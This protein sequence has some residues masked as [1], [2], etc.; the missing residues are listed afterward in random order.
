MVSASPRRQDDLGVDCGTVPLRL[1]DVGLVGREDDV[2]KLMSLVTAR[3]G[4]LGAV[5]VGPVG[6]GK[7]R[8][9]EEIAAVLV[10]NGQRVLRV[11]PTWA[12]K[13]L[14]YGALSEGERAEIQG[15]TIDR[16]VWLAGRRPTNDHR[17]TLNVTVLVD[18]A[19]L[20]DHGTAALLLDL[21]R[22]RR[23]HFLVA[24]G[25][26]DVPAPT[27]SLWKDEHLAR[28]D[29]DPLDEFAM[30]RLAAA[31]FGEAI[32]HSAVVRL[33]R[34]ADGNPM[35]LRELAHAALDQ[36]AIH[37]RDGVWVIC[38]DIVVGPRLR[39]L[40]GH[41][42]RLIT[43]PAHRALQVV[44][45][46]EPVPMALIERIS[47]GGAIAE[48]EKAALV[49]LVEHGEASGYMNAERLHVRLAH[50]LVGE[51]VRNDMGVLERR[52]LAGELVNAHADYEPSWQNS[53]LR[54][55][56]WQLEAGHAVAESA[57]LNASSAAFAV[58]DLSSA[59]RLASAAWS[60]YGTVAA[61]NQY[62]TVLFAT[63]CSVD[64]H[65]VLDSAN[66]SL[67][68]TSSCLVT[69]ARGLILEGLFDQAQVLVDGQH[70]AET[71]LCRAMIAYFRGQFAVAHG[72]ASPLL[73]SSDPAIRVEAAVFVMAAQCHMGK[74]QDALEIAERIEAD[75]PYT[76]QLAVHHDS[77]VELVAAAK[78][79]LGDLSTAVRTL[80]AE[81]ETAVARRVPRMDA[82]KGLALG[83]AL[84][85]VGRVKDA[86]KLFQFSPSY[87]VGWELWHER[88][89]VNRVL[90]SVL[91][92]DE[93][94]LDGLVSQL[95]L[96]AERF[97]IGYHL[98]AR[99]WYAHMRSD[100]DAVRAL[101]VSAAEIAL[102]HGGLADV[103]IAVHEMGRLGVAST[104]RPFWSVEVQGPFLKAR[105]DYS[106]ALAVDDVAL[107]REVA[108]CF[109][110]A[111]AVLYAAEA[112]A[113]LSRLLKR[114]GS[115]RLA[116]EAARRAR[117]HVD[118]C[119]GAMSPALALLDAAA[120][121]SKRER[122]IA[123]LAARG[124]D[125]RAIAE[126]LTLSVRTV[127]NHLHRVYFKLGLRSRRDLR[128][129]LQR[130]N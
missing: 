14:P 39:D 101:L 32:E 128:A 21:A 83:F 64:A 23:A 40:L 93:Q 46:A 86:L 57:L 125:D 72:L 1:R 104:A 73:A 126:R 54:M 31:L 28:I 27:R 69:R 85:E 88:A 10:S 95:P 130:D 22:S 20:M 13:D 58:A 3:D 116:T 122:E 71:D 60:M 75:K 87:R 17:G 106:K 70:S 33:A 124:L 127:G 42:M 79:D 52:A 108:E 80:T 115:D 8:L 92:S 48:L 96:V 78:A 105:L 129:A 4:Y 102:E 25:G 67:S 68:G 24:L 49:R 94:D 103:A 50:P 82:Q 41:Q 26:N 19:H 97:F 112:F 65:A 12:T 34:L 91:V 99:A 56:E 51:L 29:L 121:L 120:P 16:L 117:L 109:E 47:G 61:A 59:T 89:T 114:A 38:K 100:R 53:A 98:I 74:P 62:A 45:L 44:T 55:V 118:Q 63:G 111:G 9:L 36:G 18:D 30:R 81:F 123:T 5:V 90:A 43:R 6:I 15:V 7:T 84:L 77:I 110:Q 66:M 119:Q 11:A 113:E 37:R 35:F 107:L 76:G 2:R